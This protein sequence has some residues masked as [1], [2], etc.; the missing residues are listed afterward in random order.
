MDC[1]PLSRVLR[2]PQHTAATASP[3]DV[4]RGRRRLF[5]LGGMAVLCCQEVAMGTPSCAEKKTPKLKVRDV[6]I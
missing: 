5:I 3:R 2:A 1:G 4:G 6:E